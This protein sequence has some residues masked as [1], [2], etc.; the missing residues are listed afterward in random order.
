MRIVV[1]TARGHEKCPSCN[2][3]YGQSLACKKCKQEPRKV[4][5]A[6]TFEG[7]NREFIRSD[8][9]GDPL[10]L[11]KAKRLKARIEQ[12]A[13]LCSTDKVAKK[14]ILQKYIPRNRERMLFSNVRLEYIK[15]LEKKKASLK[16]RENIESIL[17]CHLS[18]FDTNDL[19]DITPGAV[20][21]WCYLK[22]DISGSYIVKCIN[23][24]RRVLKYAALREYI[25]S[26]PELPVWKTTE[27]KRHGIN[28]GQQGEILAFIPDEHKPIFLF[29]ILMGWRIAEVR[30]LK[31][32][33]IQ[34]DSIFL[35]G[36]FDREEYKEYPKVKGKKG[37]EYPKERVTNII[38]QA[39]GNGRIYGPDDYVFTFTY[40]GKRHHYKH[41]Y[42]SDIYYEA[43]EKAGYPHVT[44][45][46]F[47][48]HAMSYQLFLAGAS[49]EERAAILNNESGTVQEHY[50]TVTK[51]IRSR[52][53]N[54]LDGS[55]QTVAN[56]KKR[57]KRP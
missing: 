49:L 16:H 33:D 7:Q 38:A 4:Y 40:R 31:V 5:L 15:H 45:N 26:V 54:L 3:K 25:Q 27:I 20:E 11:E 2:T 22:T 21:D 48:R 8:L 28:A 41:R 18:Y 1:Y 36:S 9:D 44:L 23:V 55:S 24:L 57:R 43:R 29:L 37:A 10:S 13:S 51:Q 35:N 30:A 12:D 32:R 14:K 6:L 52:V 46:E 19:G 17:R 53:F 39:L 42:M 34:G 47:G 50:T 56:P